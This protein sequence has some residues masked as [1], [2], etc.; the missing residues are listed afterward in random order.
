MPFR[1]GTPPEPKTPTLSPVERKAFRELAQ[2][3][4]ARLRGVREDFADES[5]SDELHTEDQAG[6]TEP[7]EA[8]PVAPVSETASPVVGNKTGRQREQ[9]DAAVPQATPAFEPALLDRIPLGVL[10]YRHDGPHDALLYANR[11]FL[12]LSGQE[13]SRRARGDWPGQVVRRAWRRCLLAD[14]RRAIAIDPHPRW[15]PPSGR[16]PPVHGSL[17]RSFGAGTDPDQWRGRGAP[18]RQRGITRGRA[19]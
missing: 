4:T 13:S 15:R 14:G 18:T 8:L 2:E 6:A 1:Q 17:G 3:L 11:Y 19:K 16:G 10:V 7:A 5:G 12:E 9:N